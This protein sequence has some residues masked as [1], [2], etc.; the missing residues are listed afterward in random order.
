VSAEQHAGDRRSP[1]VRRLETG[2][3]RRLPQSAV[4]S[5]ELTPAAVALL[6]AI[7][8]VAPP[9]SD[10]W[11][12]YPPVLQAEHVAEILGMKV[13]SAREAARRGNIPMVRRLG[14]YVVD[15]VVFRRW[16]AGY[17]VWAEGLVPA[18]GA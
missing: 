9:T 15:Q 5:A 18:R 12:R 7:A 17:D 3:Q 14:R 4:P 13:G 1:A 6:N 2:G 11:S 8:S 16:L 10:P